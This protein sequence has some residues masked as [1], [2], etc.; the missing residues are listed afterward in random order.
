[1]FPLRDRTRRCICRT[2]FLA[3]GVAPTLSL[4]GWCLAMTSPSH[5]ASLRDQFAAAIGVNVQFEKLTHPRPGATLLEGL[6]LS[7]PET[8][9]SLAR[10][11]QLEMR[12]DDHPTC[13]IS[14]AEINAAQID[15]LWRLIERRL[16]LGGGSA[17]RFAACDFGRCIGPLAGR[18]AIIRRQRILLQRP[19]HG[20]KSGGHDAACKYFC[21]CTDRNSC[22]SLTR[23]VRSAKYHSR[24][25]LRRYTPA[26]R[27]AHH[28]GEA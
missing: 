16:Q 2:M 9:K 12:A 23:R 3:V 17:R 26:V 6:E 24:T 10:I 4:I 25:S 8:N 27:L 7:D 11:G 22:R 19:R 21:N 15:W 5:I 18:F 20:P 14:A 13:I 28:P 1:M